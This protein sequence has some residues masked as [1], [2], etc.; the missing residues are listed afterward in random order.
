MGQKAPPRRPVAP[1][2]CRPVFFPPL[3]HS[4]KAR[5]RISPAFRD[6]P[7]KFCSFTDRTIAPPASFISQFMSL[8]L[9]GSSELKR[10]SYVL[11]KP[12]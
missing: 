9:G 4:S 10:K 12:T 5:A 3:S 8:I 7:H 6:F 2:P 1:S 11:C